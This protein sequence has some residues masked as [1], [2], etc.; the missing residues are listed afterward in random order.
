L[1]A[2]LVYNYDES[3]LNSKP[4]SKLIL[5]RSET[6][7]ADSWTWVANTTL[8]TTNNTLTKTGLD[9][10]SYWGAGDSTQ[11]FPVE[12]TTFISSVNR[13]EINLTWNT[14][15]EVNSSLFAIERSQ[16]IQ[17]WLR[18]GTVDASGYSNAPKDYSF[19]D[20]MLNTG[21]YSYR[22][23]IIDNDGVFEYSPVIEAE[24]SVPTEFAISQNYP[25]PFNPSTKINYD[26]PEDSRVVLS[27]YGITGEKVADLV[28]GEVPAGYYTHQVD[29][30]G[31][32]LSSGVYIY[33]LIGQSISG[34]R[35]YN[36]VRKM[37]LVK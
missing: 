5:F 26:I 29:M 12:L 23:K 2:T 8:N 18:V 22:L 16:G 34:E 28:N 27:L 9:G 13:R 33:K 24:V 35:K 6:G 36:A 30:G 31:Y 7:A 1:N 11:P 25:N 21:K 4:E 14:A 32:N 20:R 19:T 10:F 17:T 3:E 15:T 37:M